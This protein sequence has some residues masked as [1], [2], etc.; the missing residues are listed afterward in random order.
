MIQINQLK[1]DIHHKECDLKKKI[2]KTLR[3]SEEQLI[4]YTIRKQSID[5]R[6][7][8]VLFYVYTVD[9]EVKKEKS[10]Q[11]VKNPCTWRYLSL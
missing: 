2:L 11:N 3:I 1:L 9:V 10:S 4:S 5:A 8:P 6:K 7:K